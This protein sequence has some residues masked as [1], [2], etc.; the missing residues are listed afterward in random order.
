MDDAEF[1]EEL[2]AYLSGRV[3]PNPDM[4]DVEIVWVRGRP[5]YGA[6]HIAGHGVSETEV[7]EVL[8]EIP[9]D[10][11][12]KRHPDHPN[13]TIFWGATRAGRWIFIS[14]EDWTEGDRRLLSPI[15]AF[16]PDE[17]EAYWSDQ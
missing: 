12:A 10:V 5:E 16:E 6:D 3:I 9:P 15:T 14:C 8:F 13:R 17:G 4:A 1:D 11:Q 7:E 2:D